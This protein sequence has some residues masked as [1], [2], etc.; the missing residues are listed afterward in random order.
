M[1]PKIYDCITFFQSELLFNIRY[2]VL[3]HIVDYFVIC[4]ATRTHTGKLKKINFD[5]KKWKN[6]TNKII[7]I[8]VTDIPK[9]KLMQKNKF[10]LIKFQIEKLFL[11]INDAEDNDLIMLSD[12]DEIP[13]PK[14][15]KKFNYKKYKFGIFMQ[16]LYYYKLNILNLTNGMNSWPGSRICQKKNLKSFFNLKILKIKNSNEPFWKFYKEKNIQRINKGGWHFSYLMNPKT[17]SEKIKNSGHIEYNK[18]NFTN[19]KNIKEKIKGFKDLF[20]RNIKLKKV[21]INKS[22]PKFILSNKNNFKQ[23]IAK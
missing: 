21:N 5:Y 8:K 12:E 11:G 16:N 6:K 3:K 18:P 13:N 14:T 7:F 23:W 19:I 10:D 2:N 15:I 9:I 22:Y 17:I 4:E 20:D 1:K